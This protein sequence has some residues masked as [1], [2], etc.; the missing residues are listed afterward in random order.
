MATAQPVV[1]IESVTKSFGATQAL[2][3]V[4]VSLRPGSIHALVGENGAGKSTLMKVLAGIHR[5]DAGKLLFKGAPVHWSTARGARDAGI[6]IVFQEF[7]LI[8][9][10][11]ILENLILD[12]GID[13]FSRLDR[14]AFRARVKAELSAVGLDLDPDTPVES[15]SVAELQLIEIAKGLGADAEVFIFDEPTAALPAY[16]QERFLDLI[17]NLRADG[18]SIFYISHRLAEVL[19]LCDD[20]TIIKDG[21]TVGCHPAKGL[22]EHQVVRLMVGRD[23]EDLFP[24]R[25]SAPAGEVIFSAAQIRHNGSGAP[26][27]LELRAGEIVGLAGLEGQGQLDLIR[28]LYGLVSPTANIAVNGRGSANWSVRRAVASG[29]GLVPEDRKLDGLFP[30]LGVGENLMTPVHSVRALLSPRLA[31]RS[32]QK[33]VVDALRIR[34]S[35]LGQNAAG[36][37]GGNQQKLLVGRWILRGARVLFCEELTRGV[38]I[39]ARIEIYRELRNFTNQGGAALVS[40]RDLGELLGLCDRVLVMN[41]H[42][43]VADLDAVGLSED[44]IMRC[45]LGLEGAA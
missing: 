45:A 23:P 22:S 29:V 34:M 41:D 42:R 37:S 11:S 10:L 39:G 8:P 15:L 2:N 9:E 18:K 3:G 30:K 27:S 24:E 33:E 35:G 32:R 14:N 17:R 20:V 36:L 25:P 19:D 21:S 16:D 43:I 38:D 40:S 28:E 12:A 6:S 13:G 1:E 5:P 7:A 26:Y 31:R 4:S 44:E